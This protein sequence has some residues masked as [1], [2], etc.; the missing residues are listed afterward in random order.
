MWISV[1]GN[2]DQE[3]AL[4]GQLDLEAKSSC[5]IVPTIQLCLG[6]SFVSPHSY[7]AAANVLTLSCCTLTCLTTRIVFWRGNCFTWTVFFIFW[8][9]NPAFLCLHDY[10][11][12]C[13]KDWSRRSIRAL[14][15]RCC[16]TNRFLIHRKP[17][18]A[19][20]FSTCQNDFHWLY[21]HSSCT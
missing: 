12:I 11:S 21:S 19:K 4:V 16:H 17:N 15:E 7:T 13:D 10:S 20:Y 1:I 18:T 9:E 14:R 6:L 3:V 2:W 5:A 8:N